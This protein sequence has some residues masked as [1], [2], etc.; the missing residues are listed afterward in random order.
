MSKRAVDQYHADGR[1]TVTTDKEWV[2]QVSSE[3][4]WRMLLITVPA[5]TAC[6]HWRTV[7]RSP[8]HYTYITICATFKHERK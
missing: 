2:L 4:G 5:V 3:T 1:T 6:V 8:I 7:K